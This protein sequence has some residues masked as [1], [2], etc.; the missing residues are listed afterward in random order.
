MDPELESSVAARLRSIRQRASD[1]RLALVEILRSVDHPVTIQEILADR[2]GL[3]QSSVY[4]NLL[5]LEQAGI[6]RRV[7][8]DDEYAR[9]ELNEDFTE[10]HHHLVCL[11]C[12]AVEDLPVSSGL[13]RTVQRAVEEVAA[14][15]G[16]T[17]QGHRLDMLGLCARCAET[18]SS[19]VS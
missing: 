3:A 4:R 7:V 14:N 8:T 9:Y 19:R 10:H 12:G 16:F 15:R 11:S 17:A 18:A 1:K 2:P 5:V 13:E 6:I